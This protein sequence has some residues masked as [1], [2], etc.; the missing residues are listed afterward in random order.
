MPWLAV[1]Q[2][3]GRPPRPVEIAVSPFRIGRRAGHELTLADRGASRDHARIEEAGGR[4]NVLDL[5][6][7]NGTLV[8][9][10]RLAA[11]VP[12]PLAEGDDIRIGATSL[13]FSTAAPLPLS[14]P[15]AT[16]VGPV[17][18]DLVRPLAEVALPRQVEA[19]RV[20]H[21]LAKRLLATRDIPEVAEAGLDLLARALPVERGLVALAPSPEAPLEIVAARGPAGEPASQPSRT[22]TSWVL[23]ERVAV[24]TRDARHDPRFAEGASVLAL[25][26]RSALC[27]PLWSDTG[28]EG[29][30]YLDR[31][32]G[33]QAFTETELELV[34]AVANQ[35]ALGIRQARLQAEI[36]REAVA[37]ANLARYHSP[38]VVEMILR[39]S[40]G[41]RELGIQ[42]AEGLVTV[43]FCDVCGFTA[44]AERLPA[45]EVAALLNAFYQQ[46]TEAVFRHRGSVNKYIGDSVMAIFGAPLES[47][48]HGVLAVR[49]A[50]A[51]QAAVTAL[52]T[53]LPETQRFRIRVGVNSGRV[54]VGNIGS[55]QRI[56]FTV[57]GDPVNVAQRLESVCEPGRV[58]V[59]E[60]TYRATRE[61]LRYRELG[62]V[63]LKGKQARVRA[64]EALP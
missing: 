35:V 50:L 20:L 55:A 8:N 61:V 13:R 60:E 33:G 44:L 30:V 9:G 56:E 11:G 43:L 53:S 21:E 45:A 41:G 14:D 27:V 57:L 6:S 7:V 31:R 28:T 38:D 32:L 4:W 49:A 51:V 24:V 39:E 2:A 23:R 36:R 42:V 19:F 29:V 1:A 59:G 18:P 12:R 54:V 34:T 58:L 16:R 63:A 5:G 46:V 15:E 52:Q 47:P 37:R 40:R 3:P 17:T 22:I 62:E 64:Y 10:E 25:Q 48:D 26:I